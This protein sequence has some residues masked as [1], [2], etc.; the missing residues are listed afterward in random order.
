MSHDDSKGILYLVPTPIGNEEDFSPRAQRALRECDLIA[1]EDTRETIP[2]LRHFGISKRLLSYY[3]HNEE[4]RIPEL[5]SHLNEGRSVA[6]VSD[7]GTPLISDPGYRLVSAAVKEGI[8]IVSIPGPCAAIVALSAAA[9]PTDRFY[10]AG[11]LPRQEG[12]CKAALKELVLHPSTLIFYESPHRL[13]DTLDRLLETLGDR[14]ASIG[15]NLTKKSERYFYGTFSTLQAEF[16]S[17][18]Y[19]HGEITIV[20]AGASH[21]ENEQEQWKKADRVIGILLQEQVE[22]RVI[23]D[24]LGELFTLGKREMYQRVISAQRAFHKGSEDPS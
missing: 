8:R 13:L 14:R 7:A 11:F 2:W 3:D 15:W 4:N 10:F 18:E 16:K 21:E 23:R 6:L 12:P 17:W 9:L 20:V 5:L 22:A 19:M 24:V 1:A